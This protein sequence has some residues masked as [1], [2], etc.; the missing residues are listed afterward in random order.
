[1]QLPIEW[2]PASGA[3]EQLLILLHG[4]G[5]SGG[6][7]AGLAQ[8][9]RNEFPQAAVLAPDAPNPF[10]GG[11]LGRQWFSVAGVDEANRP[12]RVAAAL[13]GLVD[14]VKATQR[15]MGVGTAATALAGFSQGGIL[16]LALALADPGIAGRVLCFGGCLVDAPHD[17][18]PHTT[19]HLFHGSADRIIPAAGSRRAIEQFAALQGD[20]TIDIADGIGHELHPALI[21]CAMERLTA[22][23]PQRT[24]REA[25]GARAI[26]SAPD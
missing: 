20:A 19:F 23:I 2:L 17:V 3:P 6:A 21:D 22:Y 14:W 4:V 15:R 26:D 13:P 12:A 18:P 9:L 10:D 7:M 1:M 8:M 24:W 16:S 5:A 11:G 25:L